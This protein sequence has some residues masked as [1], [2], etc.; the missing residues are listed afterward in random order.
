MQVDQVIGAR[1][2]C[3]LEIAFA[4]E[5]VVGAGNIYDV[6]RASGLA[7][8]Y[9]LAKAFGL[10]KIFVLVT[11]CLISLTSYQTAW[12]ATGPETEM[13]ISPE[14]LKLAE[15]AALKTLQSLQNQLSEQMAKNLVTSIEYCH[16]N[17]IPLTD[18]F[19]RDNPAVT[20]IKRTSLRLRNLK[21]K[22]TADEE[23]ILKKWEAL[24]A[25]GKPVPDFESKVFSAD[26][27]RYY[28]PLRVQA[29]CL[30]CHGQPGGELAQAIKSKFPMDRAT[31]YKE[32][33][34]RGLIRISVKPQK[35][36]EASAK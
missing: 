26:E 29:M 9:H 16:E 2:V 34:F 19:R 28:K 1:R 21:N 7:E 32:G 20:A 23:A 13:P 3:G 10:A 8:V 18:D 22:P 24:V 14:T 30:T 17:A 31:G 6:A 12:A 27:V 25:K 35:V 36:I 15:K 4:W 33:E 11:I 5:R